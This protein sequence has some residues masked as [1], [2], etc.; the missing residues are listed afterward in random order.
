MLSCDSAE[1][2]CSL[3]WTQGGGGGGSQGPQGPQGAGGVLV[4]RL[5][6][7]Q[8]DPVLNYL[9]TVT[10]TLE[11][12]DQFLDAFT[13]GA[14]LY[15]GDT[16]YCLIV[17][18]VRSTMIRSV[19]AL[20]LIQVVIQNNDI[21]NGSYVLVPNSDVYL[22]GPIGPRGTQ[23]PLGPTGA[24]LPG[25]VGPQGFQG[26]SGPTGF[27]LPGFQGTQGPQGTAGVSGVQGTQGPQGQLGTQGSQGIPGGPPYE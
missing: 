21:S 12:D 15:I 3:K 17:S 5:V 2:E 19:R 1:G 27:G 18:N 9:E 8:G 16:G 13:P 6:S 10:V 11:V 24:G 25:P 20:Q 14:E 22:A 4:A 7:I 26:P 23:G